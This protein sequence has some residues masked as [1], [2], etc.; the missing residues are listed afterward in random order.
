[1]PQ[2]HK[3]YDLVV[4]F[5]EIEKKTHNFLS[6]FLKFVEFADMQ[7]FYSGIGRYVL[8]GIQTLVEIDHRIFEAPQNIFAVL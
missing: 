1:M 5:F 8:T 4:L 3:S 2:E 7:S 6:T